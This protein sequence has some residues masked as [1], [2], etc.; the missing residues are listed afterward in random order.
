V[1][2]V[3]TI[4]CVSD[5]SALVPRCFSEKL[6]QV[7]LW[8]W[9]DVTDEFIL[10]CFSVWMGSL[11]APLDT[12]SSYRACMAARGKGGATPPAT[13]SRGHSLPPLLTTSLFGPIAWQGCH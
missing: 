9:K 12:L 7:T 8:S 1:Q 10:C 13:E 6:C 11:C 4:S 5:P 3:G 2:F